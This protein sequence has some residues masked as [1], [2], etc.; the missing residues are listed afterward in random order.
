MGRYSDR[1]HYSV[2]M[3]GA[4]V[5]KKHSE[6]RCIPNLVRKLIEMCENEL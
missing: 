6:S 4:Q 3:A 2:T 1:C 5:I